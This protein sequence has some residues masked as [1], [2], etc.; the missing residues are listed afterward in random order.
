MKFNTYK[1]NKPL[2]LLFIVVGLTILIL[3][4]GELLVRLGI[5]FGGILLI[6]YGMRLYGMQSAQQFVMRA[7]LNRSRW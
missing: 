1:Q 5:A 2:G 7:W 3:S 4:A 6:N